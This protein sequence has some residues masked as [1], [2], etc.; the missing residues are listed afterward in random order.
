M[1]RAGDGVEDGSTCGR[2]RHCSWWGHWCFCCRRIQPEAASLLRAIRRRRSRSPLRPRRRRTHTRLTN[3][4][5]R[6]GR[7]TPAP[8][9]VDHRLHIRC[10]HVETTTRLSSAHP[11]TNRDHPKHW[12]PQGESAR[13]RASAA[14]AAHALEGDAVPSADFAMGVRLAAVTC[15]KGFECTRQ[16][17]A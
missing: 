17:G 7:D 6:V 9:A 14:W 2:G 12:P 16:S 11:S 13:R 5:C 8:I 15:G 4:L 1:G 3:A 10:G